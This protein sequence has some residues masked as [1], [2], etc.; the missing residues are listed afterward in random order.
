M[1]FRDDFWTLNGGRVFG[2]LPGKLLN[3]DSPIPICL[4]HGTHK[5]GAM[6]IGHKHAPFVTR[7]SVGAPPAHNV[8]WVIWKKLQQSGSIWT[9][10]EARK[11]KVSL[12]L[13]PS[14]L[15]VLKLNDD[16]APFFGITTLYTH[17]RGVDGTNVGRYVGQRWPADSLPPVFELLR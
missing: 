2:T 4:Q 9:C 11:L 6:H 16:A 3:S 8:P 17:N 5:W 14:S 15:L 1:P 13:G 7:N 10:E 12:P